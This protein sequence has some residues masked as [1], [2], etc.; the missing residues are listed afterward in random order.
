MSTSSDTTKRLR[1]LGVPVSERTQ[2]LI[3]LEM[4][5]NDMTRQL[6]RM[7]LAQHQL[8]DTMKEML[9]RYG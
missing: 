5:I 9:R 2:E 7:A 3:V 6:G 4:A 8:V 1:E